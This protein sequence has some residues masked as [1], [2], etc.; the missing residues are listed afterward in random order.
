M[1]DRETLL[2]ATINSGDPGGG[3]TVPSSSQSVNEDPAN[4][5]DKE[6]VP[7]KGDFEILHKFELGEIST[8]VAGRTWT[9]LLY[10]TL[11]IYLFCD[12]SVYSAAVP[13]SLRDITW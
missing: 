11:A 7:A 5:D 4:E 9:I 10:I 6:P 8:R 12:L 1:S 2:S 13:K 3:V